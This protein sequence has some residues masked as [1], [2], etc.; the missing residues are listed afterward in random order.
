M[1]LL[2]HGENDFAL[3]KKIAHIKASLDGTVERIDAAELSTEQLADIFAGQ[4]LFSQKR[5][6]ILDN[7]SANSGLWGNLA[8]WVGRLSDDT[9][10]VLVEPKPDKRT[11]AYKWLK[12]HAQIEE[13]APLSEQ[14]PRAAESWLKDYAVEHAVI[15]TPQ[16]VARIVQRAGSSQWKLANAVE[17]L[18]LVDTVTDEWID[19][20]VEP[21]VTE[22]V[23][24]LF[25]TALRGDVTRLRQLIA[26]LRQTEDA[27]RVFGL[28]NS[29]AL[30]LCALCYGS[31][32]ATKTAQDI[33]AKSAYPL[34]KLAPIARRLGRDGGARII[35]LLTASDTRIKS[36]DAD[37]WLVLESTLIQMAP[38]GDY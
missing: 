7:P 33:G 19:T 11:A 13:F 18:R 36:S 8:N 31:G 22:N 21:S 23:F 9:Q 12:K 34:Q 29:Q 15:L 20:I 38:Q 24:E 27:Y 3:T 37:P 25:D 28:M 32:D 10:V 6:V 5:T 35:S 17:Q 14:N 30:Q 1:I 2:L 4:S 16:Q 26:S